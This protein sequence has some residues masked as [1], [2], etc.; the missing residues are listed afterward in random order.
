M[1][2]QVSE[3]LCETNFDQICNVRSFR[4][5]A[6]VC[7][8]S[9]SSVSCGSVRKIFRLRRSCICSYIHTYVEMYVCFNKC[10]K[11]LQLSGEF[12]NND[13]C[14]KR[15]IFVYACL[16]MCVCT[17]LCK[18]IHSVHNSVFALSLSQSFIGIY[19]FTD[20]KLHNLHSD[21]C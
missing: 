10:E 14:S 5:H 2:S 1:L 11:I 21:V 3:N 8:S 20:R 18:N 13:V 17:F 12:F 7:C 16:W 4:V 6:Y 9:I 19:S 15:F